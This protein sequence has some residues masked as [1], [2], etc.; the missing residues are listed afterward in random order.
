M[1][2]FVIQLRTKSY[3]SLTISI[4]I[5]TVIVIK[6]FQKS[7]KITSNKTL[8]A[9]YF[10]GEMLIN[11]F[12]YLFL[13]QEIGLFYTST[14]DFMFAHDRDTFC[15]LGNR[16]INFFFGKLKF[17]RRTFCILII[18]D[19]TGKPLITNTSKEFIKCRILHFLIMECCRYLV[20]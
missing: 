1:K 20:F 11:N 13:I 5:T 16:L 14:K 9:L 10:L 2:P 6:I 19:N 18:A 12:I 3:R 7:S 15:K 4:R 8:K 17:K